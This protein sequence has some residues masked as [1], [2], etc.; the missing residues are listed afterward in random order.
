[1]KRVVKSTIFR[2]LGATFSRMRAEAVFGQ[3]DGNVTFLADCGTCCFI[4]AH[5]LFN[6]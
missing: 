2:S 3:P 1:L 6:R 4:A 5:P